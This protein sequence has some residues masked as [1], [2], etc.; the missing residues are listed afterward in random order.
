MRT[1]IEQ[2]FLGQ[3]TWCNEPYDITSNDGFRTALL[4]L[5]WVLGLFTNGD[6]MAERNQF[7]QVIV[8]GMDGNAAHG[9]V[10]AE[11]FAAF[12]ECDPERTRS[13]RGVLK[14]HLVEIAHAIK[15]QAV[16]VGGLDLEILRH[17]WRCAFRR[18]ERLRFAAS[19]GRVCIHG[20]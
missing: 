14:E 3:R 6:A 18:A 9:D 7:L 4:R 10:L 8:G 5:G 11:M 20:C 1:C 12:C 16:G 15:Q 2:R 17:H 13:D 19:R